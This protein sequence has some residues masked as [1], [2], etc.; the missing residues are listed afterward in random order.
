[1]NDSTFFYQKTVSLAFALFSYTF[2]EAL[3]LR[4]GMP[5]L[6]GRYIQCAGRNGRQS[7]GD[8][9]GSRHGGN[10]VGGNNHCPQRRRRR[11]NIP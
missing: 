1:V 4:L 8:P 2:L 11:G 3:Q 5:R 6:S 10:G 7:Q 9:T